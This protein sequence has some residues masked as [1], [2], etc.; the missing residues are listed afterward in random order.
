MDL[1]TG[2]ERAAG[3]LKAAGSMS[4]M[5]AGCGLVRMC[6]YGLSYLVSRMSSLSAI[7]VV[8]FTMRS[9]REWFGYGYGADTAAKSISI[10]IANIMAAAMTIAS[11]IEA[12]VAAEA[13]VGLRFEADK[14][15]NGGEKPRYG[16]KD[17]ETTKP[18]HRSPK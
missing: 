7:I 18:A 12:A 14:D 17:L 5:I 6:L 9:G 3:R 16:P 13:P 10:A 11:A 2:V 15:I 4:G 1:S 8:P